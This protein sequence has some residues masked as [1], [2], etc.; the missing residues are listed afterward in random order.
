MR[1]L[2][3]VVGVLVLVAAVAKASLNPVRWLL[4]WWKLRR[5]LLVIGLAALLFAAADSQHGGTR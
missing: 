2:I 1:S 5:W 3:A 4:F